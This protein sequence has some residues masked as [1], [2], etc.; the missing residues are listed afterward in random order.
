MKESTRKQRFIQYFH[1]PVYKIQ[2]HSWETMNNFLLKSFKEPFWKISKI[3]L[4]DAGKLDSYTVVFN[5]DR[6]CKSNVPNFLGNCFWTTSCPSFIEHIHSTSML[7]TKCL[8]ISC[9]RYKDGIDMGKETIT[10]AYI[11]ELH[12]ECATLSS[13]FETVRSKAISGVVS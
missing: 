1:F 9:R 10:E 8:P 13:E 3:L 11:R 6:K 5:F 7:D 4:P 2:V 12:K